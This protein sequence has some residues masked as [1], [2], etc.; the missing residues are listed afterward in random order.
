[1]KR[2]KIGGKKKDI[3]QQFG[4]PPS[5]LSTIIGKKDAVLANGS[6]KVKKRNKKVEFELL[7][8]LQKGIMT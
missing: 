2:K 6:N 3:A 7:Q 4:I 1:M 8:L 5:T